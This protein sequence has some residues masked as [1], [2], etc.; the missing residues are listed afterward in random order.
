MKILILLMSCNKPLYEEEEKACRETFLNDIDE[1]R[2]S[3]WFYK[4]T[5]EM[6]PEREFDNE[7]HTLY[8]PVPDDLDGTG[9]KTLEA[10]RATLNLDYDYLIKTNVSTYLNIDKISEEIETWEGK[11]DT[12]V[13]GG[14]FLIND[15]SKNI[16]F[17]RG[18]FTVISKHMVEEMLK[19]AD[20]V[21]GKQGAPKT[22]DTLM[23]MVLCYILKKKGYDNF[24][25]KLQEVPTVFEWPNYD[26]CRSPEFANCLAIRCKVEKPDGENTTPSNIRLAHERIKSPIRLPAYRPVRLFETEF[27]LMRPLDFFKLKRLLNSIRGC[28]PGF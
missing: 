21:I 8:L 27:G 2:F 22:D 19:I 16:P 15:F 25:D 13:Y 18:Y 4:G 7:T 26:I 6:H 14:R 10:I 20:G 1:M 5:N 17:P 11:E 3:Y 28:R 24:M 23:G 9:R 12:N